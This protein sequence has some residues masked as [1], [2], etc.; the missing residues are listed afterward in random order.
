MF[1]ISTYDTDWLVVRAEQFEAARAALVAAGH[2]LE[3]E[4]PSA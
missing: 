4:L 2:A 1:V 3:G